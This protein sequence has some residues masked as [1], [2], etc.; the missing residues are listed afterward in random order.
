M[1]SVEFP[2]EVVPATAAAGRGVLALNGPLLRRVAQVRLHALAQVHRRQVRRAGA[3]RLRRRR[4]H[5]RLLGGGV[6]DSAG[7]RGG[8]VEG[9]G[10]A[11]DEVQVRHVRGVAAQQVLQVGLRPAAAAA[12]AAAIAVVLARG[13]AVAAA[14]QLF[15][16]GG[17]V[18]SLRGL[19]IVD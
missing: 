3:V 8:R 4:R 18:W 5:A 6:H 12:A 10:V 17:G 19:R 15:A 2:H 13:A 11:A 9:L 16:D 14:G 7:S 1:P